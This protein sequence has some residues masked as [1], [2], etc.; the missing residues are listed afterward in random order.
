MET[1][2]KQQFISAVELVEY[3]PNALEI[4]KKYLEQLNIQYRYIKST[5]IDQW[6]NTVGKEASIRL[7]KALRTTK[8]DGTPY[9]SNIESIT[10]ENMLKL[11]KIGLSTWFEFERIINHNG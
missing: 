11:R 6:L 3:Y 7:V 4:I 5:D 9:F 8:A 2:T 1:I 10:K